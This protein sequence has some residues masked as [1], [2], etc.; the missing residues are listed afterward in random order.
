MNIKLVYD[1]TLAKICKEKKGVFLSFLLIF[2]VNI[3]FD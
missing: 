3:S 2:C 1:T